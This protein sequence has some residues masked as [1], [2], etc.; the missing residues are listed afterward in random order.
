MQRLPASMLLPGMLVASNIYNSN[1]QLLI[2]SNT[3]LTEQI[4]LRIRGLPINSIYIKNL[5][6]EDI[7]IP[8]IISEDTRVTVGQVLYHE[9]TNFLRSGILGLERLKT[10]LD[11]LI[12][13]LILNKDTIV[14]LQDARTFNDYTICHSVNVCILAVLTAI[15]MGYNQKQLR[16]FA[17]GALLHDIGMFTIDKAVLEKMGKL[18]PEETRIVQ[19]HSENGFS[20]L[21]KIRDISTPAAHI[22][23]QH[24]ERFDGQG[25][26]RKLRSHE[27]HEYA[28]IVSIADIYDALISDRP[29]RKGFLP[30]EVYEI[31]MTLADKHIDR[32]ILNIFLET[33]AVYPIGTIVKLNTGEIGVVIQ[34]IPKL[35]FRPILR[36]LYDRHGNQPENSLEINLIEHL[37]IFVEKVLSDKEILELKC[38]IS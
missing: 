33:M 35:T 10:E 15:R 36:I 24:H 23:Y 26:P 3:V 25:Y 13:E 38:F 31:L 29:Y 30:H 22:S 4:I 12:D 17:M 37:S 27:I 1:G 5:M 14:Q 8:Q 11:V 34:V 9:V 19:A 6:L 2:R 16:D 18:S 28:R 21:R 32:E 7:H 20:T